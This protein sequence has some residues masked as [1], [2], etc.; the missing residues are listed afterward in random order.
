MLRIERLTKTFVDMVKVNS[1]S[2]SEIEMAK[3]LVNYLNERGIEARI[4]NVADKFEGNSGNVIAYIKGNLDIEPVCF[5]A[6]MDQVQPCIDVKPV[7]K[8]GMV[9]SDGTTTLGADDKAGIA[10]IL[11]AIEHIREENIPHRDIYLM[12]TVCEESGMHGCKH[13]D[14]N[15]MPAKNMVILD[16][17]GKPGAIAYKAPARY[18]IEITCYGKKAHAG[19]EPEKGVNAI[20]VASNAISN[21]HI[22]R[23]DHETTSNIGSIHGG[24]ATNIVTDEVTF[25][26]EIRSHSMETLNKELDHMKKCCE[27][28]ASKFKM[29]YKITY[30]MTYPSFELS[31]DSYVYKLTSQCLE[32]VG[33]TP[34]PMVIGGGSD[35]N[36]LAQ[37]GF[38]CAILSL[39]IYKPH[40][41]DEYVVLEELFDTTK[42]VVEMMTKDIK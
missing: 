16:S 3:W 26:A 32:S 31:K 5:Q 27:E 11:E 39:G 23:I 7:I 40:A 35:A 2:F 33:I 1:P 4:D 36:I 20:V 38:D 14:P 21:M 25:T 12:F 15:D 41:L 22:G 18:N 8:D 9:M 17:V 19:I 30:E 13:F 10:S 37:K 34:N 6:H 42:A 24:D 29:P 28:A